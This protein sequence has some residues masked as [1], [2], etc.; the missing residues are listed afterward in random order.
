MG[1]ESWAD[2]INNNTNSILDE[3]INTLQTTKMAKN[4]K[5]LDTSIFSKEEKAFFEQLDFSY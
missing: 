5:N 1:Y 3:V 2:G 4:I